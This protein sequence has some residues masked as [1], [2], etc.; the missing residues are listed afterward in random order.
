MASAS[1]TVNSGDPA[2]GVAVA[3]S[4]T[5]D[6]AL[7]SVAGCRVITWSVEGNHSEDATNPTITAAGSP[8]GAT[9]SFPMPAGAGQAYIVQCKVNAGVDELGRVVEAQT[10]RALVGVNDDAGLLPFAAGETTERSAT[11][12]WVPAL[13]GATSGLAARDT[14]LSI[15]T[16]TGT[17]HT[18]ASAEAGTKIRCTNAAGCELTIP[19]NAV[20]P[21]PVGS[22][23][24][25]LGTQDVVTLAVDGAITINVKSGIAYTGGAMCGGML[26]KVGTNEWDVDV[27]TTPP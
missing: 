18:V 9:A 3:A 5:V 11:H 16:V 20:D 25:Y 15:T 6:L 23:F 19:T 1:F 7:V 4:S 17:T 26:H 24:S 27:D 13:N 2:G 21:I 8:T 22:F 10:F 14:L 12:G